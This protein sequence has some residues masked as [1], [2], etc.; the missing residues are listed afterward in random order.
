VKDRDGTEK[1]LIAYDAKPLDPDPAPSQV[2]VRKWDG[3]ATW[4]P[5]AGPTSE[6]GLSRSTA[7]AIDP[8]IAT[9]G[10]EICVGWRGTGSAGP[11]AFVRCT[12]VQ[13]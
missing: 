11:D 13:P 1:L 4:L 8:A 7:N 12:T 9:S 3:T 10:H 5:L 6:G 2:N